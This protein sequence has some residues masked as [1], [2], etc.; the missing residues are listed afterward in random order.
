VL[1]NFQ[2]DSPD[3]SLNHSDTILENAAIFS[4]SI[5]RAKYYPETHEFVFEPYELEMIASFNARVK[6][7]ERETF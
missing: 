6:K 5:P 4:A 7:M 3:I 2:I 1:L